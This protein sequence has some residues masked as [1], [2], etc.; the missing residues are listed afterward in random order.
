[1]IVF[2]I[3]AIIFIIYL[4]KNWKYFD[5]IDALPTLFFGFLIGLVILI[6]GGPLA[7]AT[8]D[9]KKTLVYERELYEL[10]D[11]TKT[12]IYRR[13][14]KNV[15]LYTYLYINKKKDIIKKNVECEYTKLHFTKGKPRIVKYKK[16]I[17][18]PVLAFLFLNGGQKPEY[19]IYLPEDSI[20]RTFS[21]DLE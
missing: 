13:S 17:K 12:Y 2:I 6:L 7:S 18:N 15:D 11:N 19:V 8:A 5:I 14:S 9:T 1:M 20:D 10:K 16:E 21:V 3:M 4:I